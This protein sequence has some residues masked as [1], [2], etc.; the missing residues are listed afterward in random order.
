MLLALLPNSCGPLLAGQ[1][2]PTVFAGA[3][4]L[5]FLRLLQEQVIVEQVLSSKHAS[6]QQSQ[7]GE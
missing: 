5:G 3:Q 7:A 4:L 2:P 1:R 6:R